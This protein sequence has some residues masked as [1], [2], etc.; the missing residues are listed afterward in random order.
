MNRDV[1]LAVIE[2]SKEIPTIGAVASEVVRLVSDPDADFGAVARVMERDPALT[3]RV[4]RVVNSPYYCLRGEVARVDLAVGLLGMTEVRN[5]ALS[6]SVISDF[7]NRFCGEHFDWERFWEHSSGCALIAQVFCRLLRL[8]TQGVEY[9][10][11]LL[12]DVGKILLGHH[13]PEEFARAVELTV[14][15]G[16]PPARAEREVFGVDHGEL[17]LWLATRWHFPAGMRE[18][19]GF[20]HQPRRA[21]EGELLA[22]VVHLSDLLAKAKCMGYGGDLADTLADDPAWATVAQVRPEL[23]NLDVERFTF[24]LDREVEAAQDLIRAAR[25]P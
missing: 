18:A 12:H 5:I 2:G 1:V 6:V 17:G 22:A 20:H 9:V 13:F 16:V 10:A 4:L 11:G 25:A 23:Q 8:P 19:I 14:G 7:S 3:A 15:R 24:N 21:E